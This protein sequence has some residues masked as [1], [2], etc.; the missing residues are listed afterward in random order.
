MR[1][2]KKTEHLQLQHENVD[3]VE[4]LFSSR[5]EIVELNNKIAIEKLVNYLNSLELINEENK[6]ENDAFTVY[7]YGNM[8]S[9]VI[10]FSENYLYFS[11]AECWDCIYTEYYIVDSKFSDVKVSETYKFLNE[12]IDEYG[13]Y[14]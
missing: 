14:E 8:P 9:T 4:I 1:I 10:S 12:L 13:E 5:N 2:L 3:Y 11:D 6:D 7:L